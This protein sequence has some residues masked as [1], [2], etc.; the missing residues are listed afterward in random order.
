M[1]YDCTEK[2]DAELVALALEDQEAFLC[3]INK[4]QGPLLRYIKRIS[5][6]SHDDAQDVLQEVFIK[7]Y[8]HLHDYKPA[9]PFSSWVYRITRNTTISYFRKKKP[10]IHMEQ[11]DMERLVHTIGEHI[12]IKNDVIDPVLK[13]MD[14]K[15]R[16]ILV[17]KFL[18]EKSYEEISDIIQKPIGTVGT[19]V[20]RAK[21]QFLAAYKALY[22]EK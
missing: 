13:K 8:T 17:L 15:Y 19:W 9:L 22:G 7:I 16:E 20:N 3:I 2:T 1:V 12:V 6:V 21:K 18:E 10:L 11:E 5:G 14:K 4:F